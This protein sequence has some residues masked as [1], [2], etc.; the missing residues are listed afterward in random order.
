MTKTML[1]STSLMAL[2]MATAAAGQTAPAD[3][4]SPTAAPSTSADCRDGVN[5][6]SLVTQNG[7]NLDVEVSQTGTGNISDIDQIN[8]SV[9]GVNIGARV[10]QLGTNAT[11]HILQSDTG[12]VGNFN[13]QANI[14]QFQDG[15]VS[16]VRQIGTLGF[17]ATVNQTGANTAYV[18]QDGADRTLRFSVVNIRQ[19]SGSGN[20]A[21]AFQQTSDSTIENF[22]P[23]IEQL[24]NLNNA[25]IYQ[26]AGGFQFKAATSQRGDRNDSV[27]IQQ[28]VDDND[29]MNANIVQRGD[30][31]ISSVVQSGIN[32]LGQQ[33]FGFYM[34]G[35][36]QTGNDNLSRV[37]QEN[38][39]TGALTS[40]VQ[41]KQLKDGNDSFIDQR[42]G[43]GSINIAQTS[44]DTSGLVTGVS[45]NNAIS[46][47]VDN[48]RANFSRIVQQGTGRTE[49]TLTQTGF[50]NLSDIRQNAPGA[51][52]GLASAATVK[53]KGEDQSSFI[54]QNGTNDLA[55]VDQIAGSGNV[56]RVRQ[57]AGGVGNNAD[58]GQSGVDGTSSVEQSGSNNSANLLQAELTIANASAITQSGADNAADVF[59]Y[60]SN[61]ASFITQSGTDGTATVT[62]GSA[63][64]R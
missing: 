12:A 28:N 52:A 23:G 1:I 45:R 27:L 63:S 46:G 13:T 18:E 50:G 58:I 37:E 62:Q 51:A 55:F 11:S 44:T 54:E 53:Q 19:A 7:T 8:G 40:S 61:N 5:N 4:L 48:V 9:G 20:S 38:R 64:T 56:S 6:C 16:T 25:E 31:N 47:E 2:S 17:S 21:V 49:T 3:P 26:L 29:R 43:S 32:G 34:V 24:G 59:Q 41:L 35:I 30:D 57:L 39:S 22:G 36:E 60:S 33:A 42:S 10:R 14:L 15:A